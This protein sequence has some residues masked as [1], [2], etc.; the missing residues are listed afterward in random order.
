MFLSMIVFFALALYSI[1]A[2]SH[3]FLDYARRQTFAS[4]RQVSFIYKTI[5]LESVCTT[6]PERNYLLREF[7]LIDVVSLGFFARG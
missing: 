5:S 7:L 3:G 2:S 1:A 6:S 4:L